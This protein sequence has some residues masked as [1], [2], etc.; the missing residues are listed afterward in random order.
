M[1]IGE[2]EVSAID[3]TQPF[4][5]ETRYLLRETRANDQLVAYLVYAL[6]VL[7]GAAWIAAFAIAAARLVPDLRPRSMHPRVPVPS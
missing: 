6:L 2:P 5:S 7:V 1:E 4:E 3:R